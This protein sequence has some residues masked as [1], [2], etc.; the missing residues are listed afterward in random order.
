MFIY[1]IEIN[2]KK[3]HQGEIKLEYIQI[4]IWPCWFFRIY[5]NINSKVSNIYTILYMVSQIQTYIYVW[6]YNTDVYLYY[7][8][9]FTYSRGY[10][11]STKGARLEKQRRTEV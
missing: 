5:S 4:L 1:G 8:L 11:D 6:Y 10:T 7:T 2:S 3:Q 9:N